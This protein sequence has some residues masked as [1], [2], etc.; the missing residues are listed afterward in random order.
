MAHSSSWDRRVCLHPSISP[1]SLPD[2]VSLHHTYAT[3]LP[4]CSLSISFTLGHMKEGV[5]FLH[6]LLH[7]PVLLVLTGP[8]HVCPSIAFMLPTTPLPKPS[9]GTLAVRALV[10]FKGYF[11]SHPLALLALTG[12]TSSF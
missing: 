2:C 11:P 1:L 12:W 7:P 3:N 10:W 4:S 8:E 9:L 5:C 6:F